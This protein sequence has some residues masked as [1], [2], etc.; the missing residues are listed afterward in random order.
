LLDDGALDRVES[1]TARL[2]THESRVAA[3]ADPD[4]I[5]YIIYTSGS[6][7]APK[8]VQIQHRSIANL[9]H[10]LRRQPGLTG[11]DVLLAVTTISFDIAVLEIFLP[12]IVGA[13]IILARETEV[14]DGAALDTLMQRHSVTVLQ[15]TPATSRLLVAA[16]WRNP[17]LKMLCGG[18]ALSR[19]L[20]DEL[21][22]R[23]GELW[24][25]YGPTETT[26]W[27]SVLRIVRGEG[28][29]LLG[30]PIANTHFY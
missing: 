15:A 25:M 11:D 7:G 4:A 1:H 28:P 10:S 30:P 2:D 14:I 29:V 26:V 18:E 22:A 23:G 12:L 19:K 17:H 20:A 8:G 16:G 27:S 24:N 3:A 21:L 5:A 9:L 6:T 13:K